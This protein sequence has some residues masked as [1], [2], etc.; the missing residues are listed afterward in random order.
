MTKLVDLIPGGEQL[1]VPFWLS[2]VDR[3]ASKE[4]PQVCNLT[5]WIT[6]E[7]L[8][9]AAAKWGFQPPKGSARAWLSF[10]NMKCAAKGI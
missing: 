1:Y 10:P 3:R 2:T 9:G 6:E 8:A 4:S 7:P 5:A